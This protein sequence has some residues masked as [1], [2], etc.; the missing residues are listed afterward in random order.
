MSKQKKTYTGRPR[1]TGSRKSKHETG[2]SLVVADLSARSGN[3]VDGFRTLKGLL[4]DEMLRGVEDVL[5]ATVTNSLNCAPS[6]YM[7]EL[8][9]RAAC[10]SQVDTFL[11]DASMQKTINKVA[12][13]IKASHSAVQKNVEGLISR[14]TKSEKAEIRKQPPQ[15]SFFSSDGAKPLVGPAIERSLE[16]ISQEGWSSDYSLILDGE[17]SIQPV[18][19][20]GVILCSEDEKKHQEVVRELIRKFN[21]KEVFLVYSRFDPSSNPEGLGRLVTIV[22]HSNGKHAI[23]YPYQKASRQADIHWCTPYFSAYIYNDWFGGVKWG[24]GYPGSTAC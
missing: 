12:A 10:E 1:N 20:R 7:L 8:A 15:K 24:S 22:G 11:Q 6:D 13:F 18:S 17:D 4:V 21:G 9:N 2:T 19:I 14:M 5:V 3:H 23:V 16:Q